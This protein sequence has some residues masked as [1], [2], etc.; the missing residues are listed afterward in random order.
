MVRRYRISDEAKSDLN[1]IWLYLAERNLDAAD[2]VIDAC[3][4]EFAG[5]VLQPGIGHRRPDTPGDCQSWLIPRYQ[6]YV[7]V[8]RLAGETL[9]IARVLHGALDF[10]GQFKGQLDEDEK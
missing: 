8:Y 9:E 7:I 4:D 10:P 3:F 6:N 5:L 2:A 1:D